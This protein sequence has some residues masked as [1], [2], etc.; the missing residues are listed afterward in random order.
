MVQMSVR[1]SAR[2]RLAA[3]TAAAEAGL[4]LQDFIDQLIDP[5]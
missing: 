4:S 5:V 1:V 2:T 3:R